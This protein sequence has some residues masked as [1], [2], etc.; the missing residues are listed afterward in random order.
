MTTGQRADN[1]AV[2]VRPA[3]RRRQR[4]TLLAFEVIVQNQ[5]VVAIGQNQIDARPLV[6]AAEQQTDIGNNDGIR[7]GVSRK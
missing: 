2:E 4:C 7:R 6:V 3:P 1:V 5:F